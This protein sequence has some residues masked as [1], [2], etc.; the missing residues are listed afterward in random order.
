MM[1]KLVLSLTAERMTLEVVQP[2]TPRGLLDWL[3]ELLRRRKVRVMAA[4]PKVL[5]CIDVAGAITPAS[6]P[7]MLDQALVSLKTIYPTPLAGVDFEAQLGLSHA[8]LGLLVLADTQATS[9]TSSACEAY[10]QAWVKQMWHLEPATQIIRW[11]VLDDAQKLLISCIDRSIFDSLDGFSRQ[12]GMRFVGCKPA[13][14]CALNSPEQRGQGNL[15]AASA[16][17]TLVWTETGKN[18]RRTSNVQLLR[19]KGAQLA[20]IW[21]G[22]VPPPIADSSDEALEGALRRFQA[23]H[24]AQAGDALR[25]LHWPATSAESAVS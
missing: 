14:L 1:H 4:P 7:A 25:R 3:R 6:L 13:A 21:R 5:A 24:Q 16:G 20:S 10:T 9:P 12:H 19:F 8:R 18:A 15:P 11:E 2:V 23:H 17:M 22:W